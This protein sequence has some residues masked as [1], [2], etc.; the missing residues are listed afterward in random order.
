MS[1]QPTTP[2]EVQTAVKAYPRLLPRGGGSKPA[3]STPSAEVESLDLSGL[4]GIIEYQPQEFTFTALAGTPLAEVETLLNQQGQYLPF[5]PILVQHG[6]TLGGAVAAGT[7]GPGRYRYGGVRD[8]LLGVQFVDGLGELIRGGGKV[9]KNA[10]G[11]DFPKLM[12][13]SLGRL[14]VLVEL[15]FKVFPSPAAYT[16][17][18][19][20]YNG[21]HETLTSLYRLMS[22]SLDLEALELEPPGRL[23]IRLGG[24]PEALPPRLD[25]LREFLGIDRDAGEVHEGEEETAL[26]QQVR[27]FE[28]LSE[29]CSLVKIPLTPA[30]IPALEEYFLYPGGD[31]QTDARRRYSVG[32]NILWLA[33]PESLSALETI[34]TEQNL[35][36]LVLM[37][38]PDPTH[39]SQ[40][41][42]LGRQPGG[43]FS[44]RV[45]GALDPDGRFLPV[46]RV[47][48]G[49]SGVS[50][51]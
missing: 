4:S 41:P 9:V 5:D 21:L 15:T 6:A 43:A 38:P 25:R 14:G 12:V 33:W 47:P 7:S 8:F 37:G 3:L 44:R 34:L 29:G 13:G 11:F 20:T 2:A 48:S 46:P 19:L 26:W 17:L 27:E 22:A 24:L 1:L 28:W 10:A 51:S 50:E 32:G 31:G 35:T 30:R 45:K 39:L 23:W 42:L 49:V 16:T 18:R 40:S 36:G